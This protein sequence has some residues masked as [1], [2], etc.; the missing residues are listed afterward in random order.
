MAGCNELA[1]FETDLVRDLID[2]KWRTFAYQQHLYGLIVHVSYVIVLIYYINHTY[3]EQTDFEF[4]EETQKWESVAD[5]VY[6]Y[7]QAICLSYPLFLEFYRFKK[8]GL[9]YFS[10][11]SNL[12]DVSHIFFGFLNI[13]MQIVV[14]S[15]DLNSQLVMILECYLSLA[16]TFQFMKMVLA[17][18]YIVTMIL[19]VIVSLNNFIV[20]FLIQVVFFAMTFGVVASHDFGEYKHIGPFWGNCI[21]AMRLSL[22]NFNFDVFEHEMSGSDQVLFWFVWICMVLFSSLIFLTFVIARVS[23]SYETVNQTIDA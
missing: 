6:Q 18:S 7:Y 17:F 10:N 11:S 4:N 20:Y 8:S 5:P 15:F 2:Y 23:D 22:G 16:K 14:G 12:L 3:L 21:Y 13:Y 19:N 9:S 1:I